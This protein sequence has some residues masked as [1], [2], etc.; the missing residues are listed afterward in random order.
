MS[1][2][3]SD[4]PLARPRRGLRLVLLFG[5]G[6]ILALFL[7]AAADSVR[8][9]NEMRAEN[10]V[11]REASLSRSRGL[12]LVRS[13]IFLSH[14]YVADHLL[15]EDQRSSSQEQEELQTARN[16]MRSALESYRSTTL[17]E[18]VLLDQLQ[19]LLDAHWQRVTRLM[20]SP[21]EQRIA[22]GAAFYGQEV[23][24]LRSA[25]LQITT[26]VEDAEA[27]QLTSTES[28]IER[29]FEV[30]GQRLGL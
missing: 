2:L 4:A 9:L 8:L 28:E 13:Y 15:D 22:L 10:K 27:R 21:R 11:L 20:N 6:G 24:P 30:M 3:Q 18:R 29:E 19:A 7:I 14:A 1:S 26:G 25:V 23:V 12:A 17:Q 5:F 16:N